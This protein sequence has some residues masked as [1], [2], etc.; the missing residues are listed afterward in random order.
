MVTNHLLPLSALR[1]G[2][3]GTIIK[4]EEGDLSLKLMEMG[5]L[6]G[7]VI[8]IEKIA[9]LGDPISI[10]VGSYFLSLRKEEADAVLVS[11]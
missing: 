3:R 6:P 5:C 10:K 9:L 11:R 7:Q 2:E 4:L 8:S 1:K